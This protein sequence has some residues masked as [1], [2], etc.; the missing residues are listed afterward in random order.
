MKPLKKPKSA[1][2]RGAAASSGAGRKA[3]AKAVRGGTA[4][5]VKP[6][7]ST[8]RR[9]QTEAGAEPPAP[10]PTTP[11]AAGAARAKGQ[12]QAR[13]RAGRTGSETAGVGKA[14]GSGGGGARTVRGEAKTGAQGAKRPLRIPPILFEGDEAGGSVKSGPGDRYAV[15]PPQPVAAAVGTPSATESPGALGAVASGGESPLADLPRAYGTRRLFVTARDAH[16]LHLH[17]DLSDDQ[18]A[19]YTALAAR[20]HL[21][22]RLHLEEFGEEPFRQVVVTP[23]TRSWYV[24]VGR[25][26]TRYVTELGYYDAAGAWRVVAASEAVVT[27]PEAPSERG[28]EE[29]ATIPVDLSFAELVG[30][31]RSAIPETASLVQAIEELRRAGH[32]DLPAPGEVVSPLW[33]AE[34]ELALA[35]VMRLDALGRLSVGSLDVTELVR[36]RV[37]EGVSSAEAP[38]PGRL[39]PALAGVEAG[40]PAAG[41]SSDAMAGGAPARPAGFWFNVNAELVVYGATEPDARLTVAGR[42]VRLRSDGTFSLRFALPDGEYELPCVAVSGA[43]AEARAARLEFRRRTEYQG[44]VGEH[45]R[46]GELEPP[47]AKGG[48]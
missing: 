6:G 42:G 11:G 25:G 34:Q 20:G 24:E 46:A 32:L 16:W 38:R 45:P 48:D 22:L 40:G 9:R 23:G 2:A 47:G 5:P 39:G 36:G 28:E 3:K 18:L 44:E 17:W 37:G 43:G 14:A 4:G 41:V 12:G 30:R 29:F 26:D 1:S 7:R 31:V 35:E 10:S 8:A 13:A 15:M 27:P 21:V 19:Q 33:T